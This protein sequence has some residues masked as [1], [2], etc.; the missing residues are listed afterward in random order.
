MPLA[1]SIFFGLILGSFVNV[2]VWRVRNDESPYKGRS[3]CPDCGKTLHWYELVPVLSYMIQA[4]KCRSCKKH[5]SLQYPIVELIAGGIATGL[6]WHF[7][8][9]TTS[10]WVVFGLW[11]VISI[12]MLASAVYDAR[13]SQ[14]PDHF[15]VPAI[16]ASVILLAYR[17]LALGETQQT[18]S[19]LIALVLFGGTVFGLWLVSKGRWIGDGDIRLAIVMSLALTTT[20]LLVGLSFAFDTAAIIAIVLMAM[21]RKKRGDSLPIGAFLIAGTYFGLLFGS[22]VWNYIQNRLIY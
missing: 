2:L 4:G 10:D 8:P 16:A 12:F 11:G 7:K 1:L 3:H 9:S 19:Q 21:G 15:L 20:Q 14:L 5:I 22:Q 13:W 6:L 18:Y 17:A